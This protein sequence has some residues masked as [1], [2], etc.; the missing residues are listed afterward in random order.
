MNRTGRLTGAALC[1]VLTS[2]L[3]AALLTYIEIHYGHAFYSFTMWF[4]FPWGAM[5]SGMAAAS[6]YSLGARFLNLRADKSLL[7]IALTSSAAMFFF[8]QWVDYDFMT[9][10]GVLVRER[11]TFLHFLNYTI[12]HTKMHIESH[13]LRDTFSL[14]WGGYI[15]ALLQV[16]GFVGG[17]AAVYGYLS[18]Q[19]YCKECGLYMVSQG[20]QTTYFAVRDAM[21]SSV[22]TVR[23]EMEAGRL[24]H[25]VLMHKAA[26]S[27]SKKKAF[28]SSALSVAR[29][30]GCGKSQ[31]KLTVRTRASGR[32]SDLPTLT[33]STYGKEPVELQPTMGAFDQVRS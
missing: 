14:G 13:T 15:Y 17:G 28:Y 29:C 12:A 18:T 24:Q 11:V 9:Y 25:A 4:V 30:K 27:L 26:G 6:G 19:P 16:A 7:W 32:W 3:I 31:V 5:V 33:Y 23:S 22:E 20:E 8:I 2:L 21:E 1:G 10:D